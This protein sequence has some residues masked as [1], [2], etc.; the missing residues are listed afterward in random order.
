MIKRNCLDK[1]CDK[2]YSKRNTQSSERTSVGSK[3]GNVFE[4]R[5]YIIGVKIRLLVL[6]Y[7]CRS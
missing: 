6:I 1:P 7:A 3:Y 5:C 2:K 4:T